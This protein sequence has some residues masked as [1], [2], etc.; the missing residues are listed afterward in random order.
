MQGK[1]HC[2]NA[3]LDHTVAPDFS[4]ETDTGMVLRGG[5]M[6]LEFCQQLLSVAVVNSAFPTLSLEAIFGPSEPLSLFLVLLLTQPYSPKT[7]RDGFYLFTETMKVSLYLHSYVGHFVGMNLLTVA[8]F[9]SPHQPYTERD[10]YRTTSLDGG[11]F[12]LSC[13]AV[14]LT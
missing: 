12:L 13:N 11:P 3:S 9:V 6:P 14:M 8:Q 1:Y 7:I 2:I 5:W 4:L 10:Y